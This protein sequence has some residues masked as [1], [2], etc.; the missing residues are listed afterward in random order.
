M[1]RG[2][3]RWRTVAGLLLRRFQEA[4][5]LIRLLLLQAVGRGAPPATDDRGGRGG[6]STC[7]RGPGA[8]TRGRG[9]P[10]G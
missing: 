9:D 10:Q 6:A 3:E 4:S 1:D 2:A 8:A 7:D 5:P